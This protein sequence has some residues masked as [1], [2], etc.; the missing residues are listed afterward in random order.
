LEKVES[1]YELVVAAAKRARYLTEHCSADSE[2]QSEKP[3]T[4]A[5]VEIARDELFL[6]RPQRQ[7]KLK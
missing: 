7:K 4:A 3:V 5:L 1:K 2:L 6:E